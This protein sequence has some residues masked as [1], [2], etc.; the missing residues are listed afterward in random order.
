[1]IDRFCVA[2]GGLR[3]GRR[4]C[5][6]FRTPP[7]DHGRAPSLMTE[8]A[9]ITSAARGTFWRRVRDRRHRTVSALGRR[10]DLPLARKKVALVFGTRGVCFR[11]SCALGKVPRAVTAHS[12]TFLPFPSTSAEGT[13]LGAR[14]PLRLLPPTRFSIRN[15]S[16]STVPTMW[17]IVSAARRGGHLVRGPREAPRNAWF[18]SLHARRFSSSQPRHLSPSLMHAVELPAPPLSPRARRTSRCAGRAS[19]RSPGRPS[20]SPSIPRPSGSGGSTRCGRR[21]GSPSP[22][23]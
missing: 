2:A 22:A 13:G 20:R 8:R 18:S 16:R 15:G 19:A 14:H 5:P 6:T 11:N 10:W 1:M 21:R 4:R 7:R 3:A 23:R 9:D 12:A 17:W